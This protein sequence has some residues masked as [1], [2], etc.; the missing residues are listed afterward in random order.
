M[1][2][3]ILKMRVVEEDYGHFDREYVY[4][5]SDAYSLRRHAASNLKDE[6]MLGAAGTAAFALIL[7]VTLSGLALLGSIIHWGL[8]G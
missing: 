6:P 3:D 7:S 4:Q 5:F 8:K 1:A 2:S